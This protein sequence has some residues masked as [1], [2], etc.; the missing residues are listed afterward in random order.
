MPNLS[1]E[2]DGSEQNYKDIV[3]EY[4]NYVAVIAGGFGWSESEINRLP[5]V[6]ANYYVRYIHHMRESDQLVQVACSGG[7]VKHL[8]PPI[9]VYNI[10]HGDS[11]SPKQKEK[12]ASD[13]SIHL[14]KLKLLGVNV[15]RG[16]GNA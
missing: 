2:S 13:I 11:V 5:I 16:S 9:G 7:K 3:N 15:Y 8:K 14:A 6:Y 1:D 10:D 4:C 12:V